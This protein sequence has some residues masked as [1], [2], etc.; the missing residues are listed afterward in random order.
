[1]LLSNCVI[2][3]QKKQLLRK[4]NTP[5]PLHYIY[6]SK[7]K[8][9]APTPWF[10]RHARTQDN[11][12]KPDRHKLTLTVSQHQATHREPSNHTVEPTL[13]PNPNPTRRTMVS[14]SPDQE[15]FYEYYTLLGFPPPES[16]I[17]NQ[18]PSPNTN[19][20]CTPTSIEYTPQKIKKAYR[21][22]SLK[23]HP[24]KGGSP[25]TFIKCKR[26]A[27]VLAN[28]GLRK[29]YDLFGIDSGLDDAMSEEKKEDGT[30]VSKDEEEENSDA[31]NTAA[32]SN[33]RRISIEAT[34][35]ISGLLLRTLC[36]YFFL[37]V[38]R[39][40]VVVFGITL[41]VWYFVFIS[42]KSLVG[43]WDITMKGILSGGFP[44]ALTIM[45]WSGPGGWIWML[46]ES[47]ILFLVF[48]YY[49]INNEITNKI[50]LGGIALSSFL[51]ACYFQSC[52]WQYLTLFIGEGL[53]AVVL[54]LFFPLCEYLV[55]ETVNDMLKIYSDKI[56]EALA[57]ERANI[58]A[59]ME[60]N[61]K[62]GAGGGFTSS[63]LD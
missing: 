25:T 24:D 8:T 62:N 34:T 22:A 32:T 9:N 38:I 43:D 27:K 11:D 46:V 29:R 17:L 45:W 56:K 28:E 33:I 49:F 4:T 21:R 5:P 20:S 36:A 54:L 59:E 44:L 60:R 50:L 12:T 18:N 41:T 13:T 40:K 26:A 1:M 61:Y 2:K 55:Q 42:K 23:H 3:N 16:N 63:G 39:F 10:T 51:T 15:K 47:V 7:H 19:P 52:F 57:N 53:I 6:I 35:F 14:Q 58:E 48:S 31:S 30:S 37:L